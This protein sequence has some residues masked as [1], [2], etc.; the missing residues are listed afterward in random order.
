ML[1][2][3]GCRSKSTGRRQSAF[4]ARATLNGLL[5]F[6][7]ICVLA[8]TVGGAATVAS[9]RTWYPTLRKP[10]WNPPARLF[11][12]VW[13]VLYLMMAV[14]AWLVWRTRDALDVRSALAIFGLQ[15]LLNVL[16]SVVFFG[17]RRPGLGL[18]DIALLWLAI[19][20]TTVSFWSHDPTAALLL[21]P[22]LAWSA[23]RRSSICRSTA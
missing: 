9:V 4:E 13:S 16:W 1:A 19:V 7:L 10:S 6:V 14:A 15:L 12:P 3:D 18:V 11:G 22:Y 5:G 21:L 20:A 17:M 2:P 23:L 8:A